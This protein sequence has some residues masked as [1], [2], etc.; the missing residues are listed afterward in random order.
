MCD[1]PALPPSPPTPFVSHAT[2]EVDTH[3]CW[4]EVFTN[5]RTKAISLP[6]LSSEGVGY[7]QF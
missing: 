5:H 7:F 3:L 6:L 4:G 2:W 1:L